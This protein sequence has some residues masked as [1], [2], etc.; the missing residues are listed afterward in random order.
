MT[1]EGRSRVK[2]VD[3]TKLKEALKVKRSGSFEENY[4]I[5]KQ[6]SLVKNQKKAW[7]EPSS[8]L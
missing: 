6:L 2:I 4:I 1:E 8:N 7:N 3:R 5:G